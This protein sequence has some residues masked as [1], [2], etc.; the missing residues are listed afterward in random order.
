LLRAI[1]ISPSL[2]AAHY[3]YAWYLEL[4]GDHENALKHGEITKELDPL[5]P[6]YT[7]WLADQYR[8]AG[9]YDKA[10]AEARATLAF[11]PNYAV[12]TYV[13][14]TTLAEMGQ[15]DEAI[16]VHEG[17]RNSR[18][19]SFGLVISLVQA[20]R[21][22]DALAIIDGWPDDPDSAVPMI[23]AHGALQN[24]DE[25][26]RWMAVAKERHVPWY[27]WFASWFP[28]SRYLKNDPRLQ[29]I[30]TELKLEL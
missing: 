7:G 22:D 28:Q 1:E 24:S 17:L 15:L 20:G 6:F 30:A 16:A 10:L 5:S 4:I 19:W 14:G 18:F 27:P 8:S 13:L 29:A 23:L 2:V 12:A 11:N 9:M 3:H 26:F 25:F 21:R